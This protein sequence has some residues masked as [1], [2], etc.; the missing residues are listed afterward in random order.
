MSPLIG[1]NIAFSV[2]PIAVRYRGRKTTTSGLQFR[3]T[4]SL[5]VDLAYLCSAIR[6]SD[7]GSSSRLITDRRNSQRTR[8]VER[9]NTRVNPTE[10]HKDATKYEREGLV[11]IPRRSRRDVAVVTEKVNQQ[12][13]EEEEE[14]IQQRRKRRKRKRKTAGERST[15]RARRGPEMEKKEEKRCGTN[16]SPALSACTA[17]A[18]R[19]WSTHHPNLSTYG[20]PYALT[21]RKRSLLGAVWCCSYE[22]VLS[23]SFFLSSEVMSSSSVCYY[24]ASICVY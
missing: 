21:H 2:G 11:P 20:I 18:R 16:L 15:A 22:R 19:D 8:R 23:H 1:H 10:A 7:P 24:T 17:R 4:L 3:S 14:G 12:E 9:R 5:A 6:P 13:E